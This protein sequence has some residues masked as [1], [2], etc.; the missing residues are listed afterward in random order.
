M[1]FEEF[2]R[3]FRQRTTQRMVDF[4]KALAQAQARVEKTA[5]GPKAP[6]PRETQHNTPGIR[7]RSHTKGKVQGV[8]RKS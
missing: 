5:Q 7:P 6:L 4:E 2:S 1:E 8:L 3:Q